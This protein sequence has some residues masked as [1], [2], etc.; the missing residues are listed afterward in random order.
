MPEAGIVDA[1]R[2]PVGRRNGW[3]SGPHPTR[4]LGAAQSGLLARNGI[5]PGSIGQV[6]GGCVTQ[7]GEQSNNV[8]RNA[9][10]VAGLPWRTACTSIDCACGPSQQEVNMFPRRYASGQIHR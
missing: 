1:V 7:A 10:L 2:T 4:I 6:V 5:D 8:T 9:W 3:L